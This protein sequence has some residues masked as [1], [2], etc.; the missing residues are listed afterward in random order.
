MIGGFEIYHAHNL[1][2][3]ALVRGGLLSLAG[4]ALMLGGGLYWSWTYARRS[5]D[6]IILAMMVAIS[7]A[8]MFDYELLLKPTEW[9]WV[10]FWLP[11]GLA[12]GAEL[13]VRRD[14]AAIRRNDKPAGVRVTETG[15]RQPRPATRSGDPR[16]AQDVPAEMSGLHGNRCYRPAL[17]PEIHA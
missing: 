5:G 11:I 14:R 12:A 3:S 7:V 10:A 6:P 15:S 4:M 8:G 17:R 1:L 2:I 16:E 13:A 9:S